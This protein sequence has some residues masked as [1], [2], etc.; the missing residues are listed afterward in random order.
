MFLQTFLLKLQEIKCGSLY[1]EIQNALNKRESEDQEI[2]YIIG[3]AG[4]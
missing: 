3:N 2:Q 1:V 4:I